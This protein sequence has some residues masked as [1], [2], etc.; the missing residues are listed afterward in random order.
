MHTTK[1]AG[2]GSKI[3]NYW[4]PLRLDA[5]AETAPAGH[6]CPRTFILANYRGGISSVVASDLILIKGGSLTPAAA[7]TKWHGERFLSLSLARHNHILGWQTKEICTHA[8][9]V[10]LA[11]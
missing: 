6:E 5:A 10:S 3:S 7:A 2:D 11:I 1:R 9:M 4:S 8:P